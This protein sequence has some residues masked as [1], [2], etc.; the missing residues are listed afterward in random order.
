MK[1]ALEFSSAEASVRPNFA[2]DPGLTR[3][4]ALGTNVDFTFV[5]RDYSRKE[6]NVLCKY[7][8]QIARDSGAGKRIR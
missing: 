7:T 2:D 3:G 8:R 1:R 4:L 6:S 5:R